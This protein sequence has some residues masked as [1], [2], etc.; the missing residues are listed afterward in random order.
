[1]QLLYLSLSLYNSLPK[2]FRDMRTVKT[3]KFIFKPLR[4]YGIYS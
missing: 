4:I 1:M 2:Y 3:D